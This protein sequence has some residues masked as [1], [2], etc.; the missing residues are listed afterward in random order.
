M[1]HFNRFDTRRIGVLQDHFLRSEYSLTEVRV[2]YEVSRLEQPAAK[3]LATALDLDPGYLSRI[4]RRLTRVGLIQSE[5]SPHD[6]RQTLLRLSPRGRK[7]LGELDGRSS[8]LIGELLRTLPEEGQS[9]LI[10]AM[11][12]IEDLL[13]DPSRERVPYVLR[14]PRAGDMGWVL[15]RHGA[16][17]AEEYGWNE[18]FEALVAEVLSGFLRSH[19]PRR[20]RCWIAERNGQ[21]VG[22]VFV[23]KKSASVARLRMLLVEPSARSLGIG[24]RLV[25]ECIAFARHA[26]YRRL[27]LWT[28]DVLVDARRIYERA[29][30]RLVDEKKNEEFGHTTRA[31]NWELDLRPPGRR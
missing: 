26:G 15:Q 24:T 14:A 31:Q 10:G 16:L 13:E 7:A 2:L 20:E 19:D 29:G 9:R 5:P 17:Y 12:T 6:G 30:F 18:Q 23:V 28:N 27:V 3:D 11:R 22:C 4:L 21:N 8:L 1:R 25:A